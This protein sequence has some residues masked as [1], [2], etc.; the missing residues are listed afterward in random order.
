VI[1]A[2]EGAPVVADPPR[3]HLPEE[4]LERKAV[5]LHAVLAGATF[6]EVLVAGDRPDRPDGYDG[7][8]GLAGSDGI[9][10]WLWV[11]WAVLGKSGIDRAGFDS[12]VTGYRRELWS[13]LSG[14]RTWAQCCSGLI[15]RIQR[16][17]PA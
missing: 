10:G 14:G 4:P 6:D 5:W 12:L 2:G 7:Y 13:W 8:D 15:G 16:R 11:R 3:L 1:V 17:I 9:A